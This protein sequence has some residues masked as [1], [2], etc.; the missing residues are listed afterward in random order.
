MRRRDAEQSL[1]RRRADV[2]RDRVALKNQLAGLPADRVGER[3]VAVAQC[4]HGMAAI[5]IEYAAT[6][7]RFEFAAL[8]RHGDDR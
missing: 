5:E 4:G 7:R 6:V 1:C 3:R 2:E 8:R